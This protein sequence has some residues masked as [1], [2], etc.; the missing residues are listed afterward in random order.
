MLERMDYVQGADTMFI[1]NN[2]PCLC[3]AR[4]ITNAEWTLAPCTVRNQTL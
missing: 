2:V 4:R 1:F 3:R